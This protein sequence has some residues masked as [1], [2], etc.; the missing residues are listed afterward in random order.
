M[1]KLSNRELLKTKQT[2]IQQIRQY[3]IEHGSVEV[4]TNHFSNSAGTDPHIEPFVTT[5]GNLFLHTSPEFA[6]KKLLAKG[7][8]DIFQI[9]QVYRNDIIGKWH[10]QEFQMLEWYR[11]G[12]SLKEL[13]QE[14][15]D[16]VQLIYGKCETT[17]ISTREACQKFA[18]WDPWQP[19]ALLAAK[20]QWPQGPGG[21]CLAT[22]F[23]YVTIE[24]I[25]PNIGNKDLVV[26]FDFP[27][28]HAALAKISKENKLHVA[29]RFELYLHGIELANGFAELNDPAEQA[30]RFAQDLAKRAE[31]KLP[32][33]PIDQ[34]FINALTTLP[35]CCGVALGID[36]LFA[37][38]HN[39]NLLETK[40]Q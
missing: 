13:I 4:F 17:F 11:V 6:M 21:D 14:S 10:K 9:C 35:D 19:D 37:I 31:L 30:K 39:Q 36:R 27:T 16:L 24:H 12:W 15:I 3:F 1:S 32:C 29:K 38:K 28:T 18:N 23:D 26:L 33:W 8:G 7:S 34:D 20:K 2:F 22:W 25:E 5:K 40:N